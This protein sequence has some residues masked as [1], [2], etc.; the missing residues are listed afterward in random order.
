MSQLITLPE[1]HQKALENFDAQAEKIISKFTSGINAKKPPDIIYHYTNDVGLRGILESKKLWLTDIFNLNDPSELRHGVSNAVEILRARTEDGPKECKI[2]ADRFARFSQTGMP[3]SA[4]YFVCS[5]SATGDDLGQWRAYADNG[6]GYAIGFSTT[7][8][9]TEFTNIEAE[10][11]ENR[12]TFHVTYKDVDLA[13]MQRQIIDAMYTLISLPKG[14]GLSEPQLS[15][16]LKELSVSLSM[17]V[18]HSSLFFKHEA[19]SNE[20]EYRFL[21]IFSAGNPIPDLKRRF[22]PYDLVKYREFDWSDIRDRAIKKIIVGPAA[23][24]IKGMR[25]A[26]SCLKEFHTVDVVTERSTIPYRAIQ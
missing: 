26:V 21:E 24:P 23:D 5:F 1:D 10:V 14:K 6:R 16:Y 25:F 4:H 22:R 11:A 2:F 12:G 7:D 19:Y 9:E 15:Q 8:L 17:H 13:E 18:L 20:Q 3:D